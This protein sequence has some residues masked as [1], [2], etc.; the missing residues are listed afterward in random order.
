MTKQESE[1]I[2]ENIITHLDDCPN[3]LITALCE[4]VVNYYNKHNKEG[5]K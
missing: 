4:V 3:D 1:Q 2:Q 5:E